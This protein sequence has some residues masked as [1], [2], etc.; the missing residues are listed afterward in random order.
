MGCM[1]HREE[2]GVACCV[3]QMG[4][5]KSA[6]ENKENLHRGLDH[7]RLG[8]KG[9][10]SKARTLCALRHAAAVQGGQDPGQG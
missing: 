10:P 7:P 5:G 8:H 1:L 3:E 6:W 2:G 4:V 9:R